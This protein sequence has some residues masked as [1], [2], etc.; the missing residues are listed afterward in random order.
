MIGTASHR[1]LR[2]APQ[3]HNVKHTLIEQQML[4]L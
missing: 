3:M 4:H 2:S 1:V